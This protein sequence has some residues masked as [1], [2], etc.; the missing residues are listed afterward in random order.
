MN[1]A[2]WWADAACAALPGLPWTTDTDD[3]LRVPQVVVDTMLD[4]CAACP[5]RAACEQYATEAVVTG[6]WWAGV[7]RDPVARLWARVEWE[8]VRAR[9]G[10]LLAEQGLLPLP[11]TDWQA[12]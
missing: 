12:A 8:P 3:L 9:D 11:P 2:Q 6:G 10:R 7:D 5:V 4:T 1:G